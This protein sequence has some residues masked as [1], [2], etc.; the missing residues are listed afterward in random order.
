MKWKLNDTFWLLILSI[1]LSQFSVC[2]YKLQQ[3]P[4]IYYS[5]IWHKTNIN[6]SSDLS[7]ILHLK[8]VY[9]TDNSY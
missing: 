9:V 7:Y 6:L 3:F 8:F 1:W 4:Y 2:T 5:E